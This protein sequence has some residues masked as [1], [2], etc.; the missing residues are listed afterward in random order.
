MTTAMTESQTCT[1]ESL[2][3]RF[4]LPPG[5]LERYGWTDLPGGGGVEIDYGL[6]KRK[7]YRTALEGDRRFL[8]A[9]G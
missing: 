3:S 1:C 7:R 5:T 6:G 9:Q 4:R 8:W 2:E